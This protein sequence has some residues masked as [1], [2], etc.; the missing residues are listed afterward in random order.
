MCQKYKKK[1]EEADEV[2][3]LDCNNIITTG[4]LTGSDLKSPDKVPWTYKI[5]IVCVALVIQDTRLHL[6]CG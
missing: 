5:I 6:F 2:A 3:E 4:K 1:K